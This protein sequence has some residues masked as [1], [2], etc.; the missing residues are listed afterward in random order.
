MRAKIQVTLI[1][2]ILWV[3]GALGVYALFYYVPGAFENFQNF[4]GGT[5]VLPTP[6]EFI[7][8]LIVMTAI[9]FFPF[10]GF[11]SLSIDLNEEGKRK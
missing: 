10:Y 1:I 7:I 3:I 9:L 8:R 5:G 11:V 4:T 2:L 6:Q